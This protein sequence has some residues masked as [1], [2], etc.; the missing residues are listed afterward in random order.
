MK[1]TES[2]NEKVLLLFEYLRILSALSTSDVR[3]HE[4]I[5]RS[6]RAIEKELGLKKETETKKTVGITPEQAIVFWSLVSLGYGWNIAIPKE[7]YKK[8]ESALI[9]AGISEKD[10]SAHLKRVVE[11]Q[12]KHIEKMI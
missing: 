7:Y 8:A 10:K 11:A 12:I 4:E 1:M 2:K 6:V 3:L 5:T 9:K